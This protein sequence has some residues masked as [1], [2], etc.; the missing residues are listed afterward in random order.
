MNFQFIW[1]NW[2]RFSGIVLCLKMTLEFYILFTERYSMYIVIIESIK[3]RLLDKVICWFFNEKFT[4]SKNKDTNHN[5]S[6]FKWYDYHNNFDE[7]DISIYFFFRL[8]RCS[9][10]EYCYEWYTYLTGFSKFFIKG[11]RGIFGCDMLGSTL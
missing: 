11:S 2:K 7:N 1:T 8:I 9:S 3:N 5:M 4:P 6:W 10:H